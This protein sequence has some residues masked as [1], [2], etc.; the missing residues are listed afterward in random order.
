MPPRYGQD[1][2]PIMRYRTNII[3][4]MNAYPPGSASLIVALDALITTAVER[5]QEAR[6]DEIAEKSCQ[7]LHP[8]AP[9]GL[10]CKR[11]FDSKEL[12]LIPSA[13]EED[14]GLIIKMP[15]QQ[16]N[17]IEKQVR[18]LIGQPEPEE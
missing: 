14:Q 4:V 18:M 12:G 2:K 16:E 15:A 13:E 8:G 6:L 17:D 5:L 1:G 7:Q 10:V 9:K 11:C 3:R